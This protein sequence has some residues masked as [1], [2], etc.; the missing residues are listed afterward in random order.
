MHGSEKS[1]DVTHVSNYTV[2]ES[3]SLIVHSLDLITPDHVIP[4]DF[5]YLDLCTEQIS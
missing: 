1:S 4:K 2:I 3:G 5:D